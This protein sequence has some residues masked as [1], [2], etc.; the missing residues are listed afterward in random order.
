MPNNLAKSLLSY[1]CPLCRESEGGVPLG[2]EDTGFSDGL[3]P[4]FEVLE[5]GGEEAEEAE[6]AEEG[7][8]GG[9][10]EDSGYSKTAVAL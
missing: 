7:G 4:Q 10:E 1:Q 9:G 8:G 6:E 5:D 2:A 3:K